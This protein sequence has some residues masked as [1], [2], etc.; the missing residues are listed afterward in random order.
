MLKWFDSTEVDKFADWLT[1]ELLKRYPPTG[2]DTDPKK[3]TQRLQKV[4]NNLFLRVQAFAREQP[5]NIYQR[6]RLG[7]RVKWTMREAGYPPHFVEA[8]TGEVVTVISVIKA[9]PREA[10]QKR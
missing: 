10:S 4:H 8:F 5:L 9:A 1:A 6:A 3:A 2:L 7:N